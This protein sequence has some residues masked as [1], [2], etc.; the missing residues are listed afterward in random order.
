MAHYIIKLSRLVSG[1]KDWSFD[2]QMHDQSN[3]RRYS[4]AIEKR[5]I[6]H[7]VHCKFTC[8]ASSYQDNSNPRE[9]KSH[10]SRSYFNPKGNGALSGEDSQNS[11]VARY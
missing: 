3:A 8:N 7:L 6:T 4:A 5:L 9:E 10:R 1:L 11:R 2:E